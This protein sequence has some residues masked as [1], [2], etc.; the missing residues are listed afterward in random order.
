MSEDLLVVVPTF[1]PEIDVVATLEQIAGTAR[2]LVVDDGSSCTFDPVLR[3]ISNIPNVTVRRFPANAGIARSLNLG[4]SEASASGT[5]WLLTIDQDSRIE[6]D[7]PR[8]AVAEATSAQESGVRVGALGAGHVLDVSGPINYPTFTI[9]SGR[10]AFHATH[11]VLLSGT[12]WNVHLLTELQ[13]F[14]E[15]FGMDAVDAAAC[16]AVRQ[17]GYAVLLSQELTLHHHLGRAE[18]V[19]FLGRTVLKTGHSSKRRHAM[20]R[21]RLRLFPSEFRQAPIHAFRTV[22]RAVVNQA[23]SSFPDTWKKE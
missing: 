15:D 1:R 16:L 13:G 9:E 20:V 23:V 14:R 5:K 2:V 12:L 11:E 17:R 18:R 8:I 4:L 7:Y 19:N 21:N 22:R 6:A 10:R 3:D